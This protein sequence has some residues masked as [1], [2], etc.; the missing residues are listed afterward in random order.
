MSWV[1][2]YSSS[3]RCETGEGLFVGALVPIPSRVR[4]RRARHKPVGDD[5][6]LPKVWQSGARPD[7]D[8]YA[9]AVAGWRAQTMPD[10][11][12]HVTKQNEEQDR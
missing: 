11:E 5:P 3:R 12:H 1:V 8:Q 4:V 10:V 2:S 7:P 9:D 6:E